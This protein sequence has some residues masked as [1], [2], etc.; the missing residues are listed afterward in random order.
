VR[1]GG[2]DAVSELVQIELAETDR[3]RGRK[4]LDHG[5][6]P[7]GHVVFV[8]ARAGR[9]ADTAREEQVFIGDR[10]AVQRPART[11]AGELGIG[12][13]G[14]R[15]RELFRDGEERI[16]LGVAAADAG[17]GIR[18]QL[19]RGHAPGAQG[20]SGFEDRHAAVS[21][22]EG[23]KA[24]AG[25]SSNVRPSASGR[26]DSSRARRIGEMRAS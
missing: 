21:G 14:L 17:Q 25:S 19:D 9:G 5:G 16:Q 20:G 7:I 12:R 10:N 22:T 11:A 1:I 2:R 3:A 15:Q 26:K 6:I 18:G 23:S 13:G 4:L 8:K 24:T